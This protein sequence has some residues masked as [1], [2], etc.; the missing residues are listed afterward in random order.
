MIVV[1]I[2]VLALIAYAK[3][4]KHKGLNAKFVPSGHTTIAFAAT[5][6]IWLVTDNIVILMLALVMA[7]LIAESRAAAKEHK[8]SEIIF[9]GCFGTAMTL[10]LYGIAYAVIQLL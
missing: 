8:L 7:I 9:S 2:A 5:T 4:N 3:T 1:V 10:I 6:I